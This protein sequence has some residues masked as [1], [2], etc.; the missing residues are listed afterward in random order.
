VGVFLRGIRRLNDGTYSENARTEA[1]VRPIRS[2]SLPS[3]LLRF[4]A[5]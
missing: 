5:P 4:A 2:V 3:K 1:V